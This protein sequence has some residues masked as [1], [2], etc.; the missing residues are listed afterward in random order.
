M[1]HSLLILVLLT[2][3]ATSVPVTTKFPDAPVEMMKTCPDLKAIDP[4][5]T[6]L[7][8]VL[9]TVVD[10]YGQYYDCKANT[11]DWIEWYNTQKKIFNGVK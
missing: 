2:G 8:E 9:T 11:D 10:N 3:C 1:K 5:V 6:K 7:S 4:A